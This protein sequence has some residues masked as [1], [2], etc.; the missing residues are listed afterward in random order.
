MELL[1]QSMEL[2]S[3]ESL[4]T[5]LKEDGFGQDPGG[6]EQM[7]GTLVNRGLTRDEAEKQYEAELLFAKEFG[8]DSYLLCAPN[9]KITFGKVKR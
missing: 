7:I 2:S 3:K 9:M 8:A 4:F 1:D 6:M 5:S